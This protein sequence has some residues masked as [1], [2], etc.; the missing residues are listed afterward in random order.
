MPHNDQSR[1]LWSILALNI[2]E[3]LKYRNI[4]GDLDATSIQP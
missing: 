2:V 4:G 1:L 3:V